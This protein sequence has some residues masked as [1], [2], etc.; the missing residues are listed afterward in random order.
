VTAALSVSG[1]VKRFGSVEALGGV[2]FTA[3]EGEFFTIVGPTNAGKSTLLK[4]IAGLHAPDAGEVAIDGR[5]IT[6]LEPRRRGVSLLFQNAALF[7]N[8]TGFENIAF[9]LRAAGTGTAEIERRVGEVAG[10]LGV[11]HLLGRHPR[12][13]SGGEQQRVAI[14]RALAHRVPVVMLD[15][16]LTNLDARTRIALRIEFKALHRELGQTILYVTHDQV[17]AM[18]LS[19][20]ILGLSG[21]RV[22][23]IGTADEVYR[24]PATRF[25]AEF[26]GSPP[27]NILEVELEDTAEGQVVRAPGLT[28]RVPGPL[29]P[30]GKRGRIG[31]GVRPEEVAVA[32][33]PGDATPIAGEVFW[34]EHLGDRSILDSRLGGQTVK[35]AVPPRHPVSG[36]GRAFF[37]LAPRPEHLLDLSSGRFFR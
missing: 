32:P 7:P 31:L 14:G 17:E 8:L 19:D 16:P 21:G 34:V 22:E 26:I 1:L 35:V 24:R 27:M 29:P 25:V 37:G 15:E 5:D 9:P 6:D 23:Q 4:T 13:Y 11:G 28:L 36:V 2:S 12:T 20:R 3:G 30:G 10:K 33:E 18:S